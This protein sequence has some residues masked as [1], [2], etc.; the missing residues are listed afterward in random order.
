VRTLALGVALVLVAAACGGSDRGDEQ[1]GGEPTGTEAPASAAGTFGDLASPCGP[2]DATGATDQGVTDTSITI[3]YGDDAGY[4]PAPG[5]NGELTDAVEAMIAWCNEQGGINGREVVGNYYDAAVTEVVN[6]MTQACGEVFFLVGQGWVLDS[7]QEQVRRGC[8]LPSVP[9]Y[10]VSPQFSNAPGVFQPVPNPV[11]AISVQMA[12]AMAELFPE[13]VKRSSVL[14]ADYP[15]TR[16]S[17]DKVVQSFREFGFEFLDCPVVYGIAGEADW[18]PLAQALKDCGAEVV[19]FAG[20]PYPN[21]QNYLEAAAQVGYDPIYVTDANNYDETLA[22]WNTNG[23]GDGVYVRQTF[24]P[25]FEADQAPAIQ[26]YID[27]VEATGGEVNQ[28]GEQAASAF[29]LWATAARACGSDLTRACVLE[30]LAQVEDWTGGGLHA[31]GDPGRN[32]PTE[33][34]LVLKLEGTSFRRVAPEEPG[35]FDCDPS[36]VVEVTGPVV[37]QANLDAD[38]ISQLG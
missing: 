10:A 6:A 30:Q 4:A 31:P 7:G 35:S 22:A 5:L 21:F 29:L 11:D 1:A 32:L 16:D 38:R 27:A 13:Q 20:S 33:C 9:G 12:S 14:Y 34:G 3:G 17:K 18:R 8:E 37:D 28:L 24:L 25:L 36:Y 2:G 15:P 19:Y 26:Q 23:Y